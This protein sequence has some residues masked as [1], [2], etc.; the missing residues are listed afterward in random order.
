VSHDELALMIPIV[1]VGGA[2]LVA[3]VGIVASATS[4]TMQTKAREESRREIAAYVAE[5]TISPDE[6]T[7]LLNAGT[8]AGQVK[9]KMNA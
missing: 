1:A 7:R 9:Q 5:G 4:K 8:R 6:A 2:F 3:I